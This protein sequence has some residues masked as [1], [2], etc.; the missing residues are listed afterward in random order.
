MVGAGVDE[1]SFR[2]YSVERLFRT[3][4]GVSAT[5]SQRRLGACVGGVEEIEGAGGSS[6]WRASV[7]IEG[8]YQ[9]WVCG[10]CRG[11]ESILQRDLMKLTL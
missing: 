5:E 1:C 4:A 8:S 2:L 7:R 6:E 11:R 10:D 3:G 9:S